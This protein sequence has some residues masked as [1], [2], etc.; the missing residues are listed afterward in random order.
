MPRVLLVCTANICRSP[1]AQLFLANALRSRNIQVDSAGTLAV[2]G[3]VA[4]S[5]VREIMSKRGYPEI[6]EHRSKELL[7]SHLRSYELI[8]CMERAH[9]QRAID[10][11]P[12][13][14]GK[15]MLFGHWDGGKEVA[16]PIGLPRENY[17]QALEMMY[18]Y[19]EQ[20]ANKIIN[21]EMFK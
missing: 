3:N 17:V 8:L 6:L 18:T 14:L 10:L 15:V 4:D 1:A 7:P 19:A 11:N 9:L 21:L 12:S 16:D 2:A 5:M 13:A 20:W